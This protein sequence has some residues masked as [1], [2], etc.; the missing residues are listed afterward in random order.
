MPNQIR[1]IKTVDS[2][3]RSYIFEQNVSIYLKGHGIVRCNVYRP[4]GSDPNARYPVLVTYGPYGKDVPYQR[5]VAAFVTGI[6]MSHC[7][8]LTISKLSPTKL[9]RG[10]P[11]SSNPRFRMGDPNAE[12]LDR[13]RVRRCASRRGGNWPVTRN[14][15]SSVCENNRCILRGD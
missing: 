9:L 7:S 3:S 14:A 11:D 13:T 2:E 12:I 10:E 4:K 8:A 1:D 5:F 6:D 15:Q